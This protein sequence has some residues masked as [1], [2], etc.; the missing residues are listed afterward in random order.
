M[1]VEALLTESERF[2][3]A[4]SSA[5]TAPPRWSLTASAE[6]AP[7]HL[8]L[9]DA[10]G[11]P[12]I[13]AREVVEAVRAHA[14]RPL[15][16]HL[17]SPGGD[18]FAG[19]A[20]HNTLRHHGAPVDVRVEGLAAS[21]ASVIAMSGSTLRMA[22][23]SLLMMHEPRALV[24]GTGHDM[25]AMAG[26]L[27]KAAGVMADIYAR[28]GVDRD[29]VRRWMHAETW[30][31]AADALD[32]KLIDALDE[33]PIP[34]NALKAMATFDY[35]AF[36]ARPG[37]DPPADPPRPPRARERARVLAHGFDL[38]MGRAVAALDTVEKVAAAAPFD[39]TKHPRHDKGKREGGR[40]RDADAGPETVTMRGEGEQIATEEVAALTR[41]NHFYRGMTPDEYEATVGLG[42]GVRSRQDFSVRDEGTSFSH[43]ADDAETYVNY[44]R[45]DPRR[46][47]RPTYLVEVEG[48]EGINYDRRDGYY[49]AP[50]PIPQDR[51]R[52]VYEMRAEGN[53][54]IGRLILPPDPVEDDPRAAFPSHDSRRRTV[55]RRAEPAPMRGR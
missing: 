35:S 19:L 2:R 21:I 31:T 1:N 27:D 23:A 46:T 29:A 25:R 37:A 34:D 6:G 40:F 38:L 12:G 4:P 43:L 8:Y 24:I 53:A 54:I 30:W 42:R 36:R 55:R 9:Y 49:K 32:A 26:L 33:A 28:R 20:I 16:V 11:F 48:S 52:R 5:P 14:E 51:I 3:R 15:H 13:E 18:V 47:G 44:G 45:D 39:P 41:K 10:I 22:R 17:N 50:K 7:A